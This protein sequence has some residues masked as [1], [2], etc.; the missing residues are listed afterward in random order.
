MQWSI[1]ALYVPSPA[2]QNKCYPKGVRM[3]EKLQLTGALCNY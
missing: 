2:Q 1:K 3:S